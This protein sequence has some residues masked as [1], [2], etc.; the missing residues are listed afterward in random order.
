MKRTLILFL[1][2]LAVFIVR[3]QNVQL[4]YDLGHSLY[5][6][7]SVRPSVTTTLEMYK[8]DRWGNTFFFAD[9][10]YFHDGVAGV[11]WEISREFNIWWDERWAAHVEY[12]GG[13]ASSQL[14][15]MSTRFQHAFLAGLAWN[16]GNVDFT[17]SLSIQALYKYYFKGQHPW[18]RPYSGFQATAVWALNTSNRLF[19]FSGF[20]DS[21]YDPSVR[22]NWITITEP[23]LWININALRGCKQVKLSLGTEV[24]ISNN[25][26]FD[27]NGRN[28]HFYAIPTIAAKW[29][30]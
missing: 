29:S 12:D 6:E 27:K 3:G 9:I 8:P 24:E 16:W 15:D 28:D 20:I 7:L 25:F 30:F 17:Q 10:D 1:L 18:N 13:T 5:D 23:Q 4:H 14:N 26:I 2:C 22:G 19:T 21:W 11:Y